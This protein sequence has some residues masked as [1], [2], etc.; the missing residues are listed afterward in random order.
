MNIL[1]H[2]AGQSPSAAGAVPGWRWELSANNGFFES[3]SHIVQWISSQLKYAGNSVWPLVLKE[4]HRYLNRYYSPFGIEPQV[5]AEDERKWYWLIWNLNLLK[6]IHKITV[7]LNV[8]AWNKTRHIYDDIA[9]SAWLFCYLIL[10]QV[11]CHLENFRSFH[12]NY[13]HEV[14]V[15]LEYI[16]L[17]DLFQWTHIVIMVYNNDNG[18]YQLANMHKLLNFFLSSVDCFPGYVRVWE[19]VT[20]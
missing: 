20:S 10:H 4:R 14:V 18:V 12:Q 7:G 15:A 17:I 13:T 3:W 6:T 8:S 19:V 9:S 11:Y 1:Y 5:Q 2:T 16:K